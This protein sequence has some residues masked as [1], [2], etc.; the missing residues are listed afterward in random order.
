M[1]SPIDSSTSDERLY[2]GAGRP[3]SW[4][5][6]NTRI[7]PPMATNPYRALRNGKWPLIPTRNSTVARYTVSRTY[8]SPV[9][10]ASAPFL[11]FSSACASSG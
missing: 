4:I 10:P 11:K 9:D 8:L 6:A 3:S 5:T 1:A 2:G 7:R